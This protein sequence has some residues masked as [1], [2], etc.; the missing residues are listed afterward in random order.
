M[1]SQSTVPDPLL[2]L[3][4][5]NALVTGAARGIGAGI[6][7]A[8]A[9]AGANVAVNDIREPSETLADCIATGRRAVAAVADVS[10]QKSVERMVDQV[11]SAR[12]EVEIRH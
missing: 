10:D 6:A 7:K 12:L 3:L 4:G 8:L 9:A 5:K 11:E 1:S 2:P